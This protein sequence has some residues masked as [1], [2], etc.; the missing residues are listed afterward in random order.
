MQPT[1]GLKP[2]ARAALHLSRRHPVLTLEDLRA[3]CIVDP[4]THCWVWQAGCTKGRPCV[5]TFDHSKGEKNRMSGPL[6]AWHIAHQRPPSRGAIVYRC[7]TGE[8]SRLCV[9]PAHM[10]QA[11]SRQELNAISGRSGRL[12]GLHS[13]ARL[14]SLQRARQVRGTNVVPDDVVRQLRLA[15]ATVSHTSL[16]KQYGCN[17]ETIRRIRAGIS[18]AGVV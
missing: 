18:R 2:V 10:R 1:D 5:Y 16:A 9:N 17:T 7:C 3:R 13:E 6:A 11:F 14:Q 15:P 12:K 8:S 4:V